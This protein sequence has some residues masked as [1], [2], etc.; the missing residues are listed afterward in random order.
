MSPASDSSSPGIPDS[1]S[2][3]PKSTKL[4]LVETE[5]DA[6]E[7]SL[8]LLIKSSAF[9]FDLCAAS[10]TNWKSPANPGRIDKRQP[11]WV[12]FIAEMKRN[13]PLQIE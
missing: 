8:D 10:G 1:P 6:P 11:M 3:R 13:R 7:A 9:F 2:W 4:V 12:P 5:A